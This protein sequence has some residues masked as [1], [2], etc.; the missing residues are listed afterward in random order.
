MISYSFHL[1]SKKHALTTCRKVS[2]ASKHNL[3]KYESDE[4][5]KR[6]IEI[7]RG[8]DSNILD[9][10]KEV[11]HQEFD[12][13]VAEYNVGKRSDRKIE[14]YIKYVSDSSKND[15]A[16]EVIMQIGDKEF[17]SDKT[18]EQKRACVK[19][20]EEQLER[21]EELV[22]EF[23]VA[24]AVVHL[25]ESSPHMHVVGVPVADG[26]KRGPKKQVAKTKIFTQE[27]LQMLQE[28]MHQFAQNQMGAH[29]GIFGEEELKHIERGRNSDF[30]KEFFIRQKEE[31]VKT[32][33]Y[34]I[35]E[36]REQIESLEQ[37]AEQLHEDTQKEVERF[38]KAKTDATMKNDFFRF[39]TQENPTSELARL[40]CKVWNGF[41]AW[42]ERV[43][44]PEVEKEA[45]ESVLMKLQQHKQKSGE[46][47]VVDRKKEKKKDQYR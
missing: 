22:P 37:L 18:E 31:Q 23:K 38:V 30:S 35:E 29:P 17:W 33:D 3:R 25:D 4:Y 39:V 41:K 21:L 16:A 15:V 36:K 40:A 14:N 19:L 5:D 11:Y 26:Y 43:K 10:V 20:L 7:L 1:S 46:Q 34:V 12:E 6:F 44:K 8:G 42:W 45:R 2:G 9:D 32:L 28:Q 27:S 24:S 47:P 13:A